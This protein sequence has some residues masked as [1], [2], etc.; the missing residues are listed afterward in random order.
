VSAA[1]PMACAVV[2]GLAVACRPPEPTATGSAR[3]VSQVVFADEEL[4]HLGPDVRPRVVGV[5]PMADDP[6][7]SDAVGLWPAELPRPTGAEAIAAQNPD[8]VVIAEFTADETRALLE[9][10]GVRTLRLEGWDGFA[11]VRRHIRELAGAVGAE[12]AGTA[13]IAAFDAELDALRQRF[14]TA[15]APG[16]VSWED[17]SVAGGK[18][19]F[20]DA[21]EAAGFVDVAAAHGIA[22]HRTIGLESLVAWDPEYI[23]I[24][25][26]DDCTAREQEFAAQPGIAAT[27]AGRRGGVIAMPTHHLY[28][29]GFGALEM[30]RQLGERRRGTD[31]SAP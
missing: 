26:T 9:Q 29:V 1:R 20:A 18:T 30:V 22:G 2:L 23:V 12:A 10:M 15:G 6:R 13:R 7:Y 28:S 5:S 21:A 4:W 3:I 31:G 11:D 17:G 16:I 25:C 19:I 24:S 14:A 27:R 8:L